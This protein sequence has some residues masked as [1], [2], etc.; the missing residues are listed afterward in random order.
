VLPSLFE[1][2]CGVAMVRVKVVGAVTAALQCYYFV[3][4][5]FNKV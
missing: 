2:Y 1:V 4:L 3:A 5:L